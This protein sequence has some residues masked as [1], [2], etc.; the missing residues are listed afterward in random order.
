SASATLA[1]RTTTT[2][3]A[4]SDDVAKNSPT[5]TIAIPD[6]KV[7]AGKWSKNSNIANGTLSA[8]AA[9]MRPPSPPMPSSSI[10]DQPNVTNHTRVNTEGATRT[11]PTNWRTVRPREMRARKTPMNGAHVTVHAR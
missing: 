9:E 11:P 7:A 4:E 8:T 5:T 1:R 6:T 10:A 3:E 2:R